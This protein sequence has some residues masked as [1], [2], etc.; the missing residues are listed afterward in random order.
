MAQRGLA[1]HSASAAVID[2]DLPEHIRRTLADH[3]DALPAVDAEPAGARQRWGE[4]GTAALHAPLWVLLPAL[5]GR[6]SAVRVRNCAFTAQPLVIVWAV[7]HPSSLLAAAVPAQ[8]VAFAVLAAASRRDRSFQ[9][10][11]RHRDAYVRPAD[12]APEE[13]AL[14]ERA[15]QAVEIV[16]ESRVHCAGLLDDVKN[17]RTLPRQLW[18][19]ARR[20]AD[21][22]A[23]RGADR[24]RARSAL[25]QAIRAAEQRVSALESYAMSAMEADELLAEWDSLEASAF[26]DRDEFLG[27]MARDELAV[28]EIDALTDEGRRLGKSLRTSVDRTRKVGL[29]LMPKS[30]KANRHD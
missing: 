8:A 25:R 5:I 21:I 10:A 30:T 2:P 11:L 26:N 20:L 17:S 28:A 29:V 7:I 15:R 6:S 16:L 13:R 22:S 9:L 4:L 19:L 23:R 14:L 3:Q 27:A 24:R 12:L 1:E 18:D